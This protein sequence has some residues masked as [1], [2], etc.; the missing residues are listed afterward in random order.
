MKTFRWLTHTNDPDLEKE[1]AQKIKEIQAVENDIPGVVIVHNLPDDSIVY[2]SAR[3]RKIL[4]VTLEEIRLP[5]F[6]YHRQFFNPEDVPNY[7]PKIFGMVQRN[8]SDEMITFFQ[9]VRASPKEDWK[10]YSSS[11]KILLRDKEGKPMLSITVA[12][13]IDAEHYITPKIERLIEEN[14]FLRKHQSAFASLSKREIEILR[15]LALGFSSHEIAALLFISEE[16]VKTHR[17]NIRNKL[18]ADST[19]DLVKF[20]QA[21]NLI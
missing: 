12:L 3:G 21:F 5:H 1:T 10:W 18:N 19:F 11:M 4:Q 16:T 6:D 20:A 9:Q 8:T 13:P 2:L 15:H 17:K 7:S 14:L